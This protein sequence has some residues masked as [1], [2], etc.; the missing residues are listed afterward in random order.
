MKLKSYKGFTI[1]EVVLVLAIAGLIFLMVLI[2]LPNMQR[3][4]RDTA[5][6]NDYA[7][8]TANITSYLTNNNGHLPGACTPATEN[9][10]CAQPEKYVN[11]D[12]ED[13]AGHDYIITVKAYDASMSAMAEMA[14]SD[15][16]QIWLVTGAQCG[17]N[18]GT[19]EFSSGNRDFA[20]LGQLET[21]VFCQDNV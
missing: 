2:A 7:A 13:S 6:R 16:P 15:D 17:T 19:V 8:F 10:I 18:Q 9:S 21:G 5:R 20:V 12:G 14:Q 3:S 1:I 4:Q 11:P